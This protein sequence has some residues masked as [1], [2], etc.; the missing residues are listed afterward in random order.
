MEDSRRK[1]LK[2]DILIGLFVIS[3]YLQLYIYIL[4]VE[5]K[6]GGDIF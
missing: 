6:H 4:Y 3:K 2:T 5:K 1:I